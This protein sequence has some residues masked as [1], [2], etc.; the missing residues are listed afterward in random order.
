VDWTLPA[1]GFSLQSNPSLTGFW[2]DSA[3]TPLSYSGV[4]KALVTT[5]DLPAANAGY[6]RLIKRVASQL[7]VL[8]PGETNAPNTLSGKTGTPDPQLVQNFVPVTVNAVDSTWH[9]VTS[10]NDTVHLTTTD[11]GAV[12]YLPADT[13]LVNGT[14]TFSSFYFMDAGTWTVTASD[15]DKPAVTSGTSTGVVVTP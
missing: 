7:Q 3:A 4:L 8:L 10:V 15:V 11:T 6:F 1:V 12:P 9:I 5:S 2:A 13:A 14:V